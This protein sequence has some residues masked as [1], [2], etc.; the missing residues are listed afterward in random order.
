MEFTKI[1]SNQ[2]CQAAM[3]TMVDMILAHSPNKDYTSSLFKRHFGIDGYAERVTQLSALYIPFY[4][5][6]RH[7]DSDN[8]GAQNAAEIFLNIFMDIVTNMEN[9]TRIDEP[10]DFFKRVR[11]S[12]DMEFLG[13]QHVLE[14]LTIVANDKEPFAASEPTDVSVSLDF[15]ETPLCRYSSEQVLLIIYLYIYLLREC[16]YTAPSKPDQ[17]DYLISDPGMIYF[18]YF[19]ESPQTKISR[20]QNLNRDKHAVDVFDEIWLIMLDQ[21]D[22]YKWL[23]RNGKEQVRENVIA[24]L[25]VYAAYY[26]SLTGEN[27]SHVYQLERSRVQYEVTEFHPDWDEPDIYTNFEEQYDKLMVDVFNIVNIPHSIGKTICFRDKWMLGASYIEVTF[28]KLNEIVH[29][30][31]ATTIRLAMNVKIHNSDE[32]LGDVD[33]CF[34]PEIV[35]NFKPRDFEALGVDT[36]DTVDTSSKASEDDEIDL[37]F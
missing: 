34:L 30:E 17:M 29:D 31:N 26:E 15:L 13:R 3:Q 27:Y 28:K 32:H 25:P 23:V 14:Q 6:S 16:I 11:S 37:S 8:L 7:L 20:F 12:L 10:S 36:E 24:W 1:L 19:L 21:Y 4:V 33:V 18:E 5:Q 9:T 2:F 22:L 35:K